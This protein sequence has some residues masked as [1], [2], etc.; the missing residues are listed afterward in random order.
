MSAAIPPPTSTQ[1]KDYLTTTLPTQIE[2]VNGKDYVAQL[3]NWFGELSADAQ[4][5]QGVRRGLLNP[6]L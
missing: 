4:Q 1:I 3:D 2:E 6:A 5:Q